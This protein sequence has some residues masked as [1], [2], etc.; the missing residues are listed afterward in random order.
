MKKLMIGFY[1]NRGNIKG[2]NGKKN[3]RQWNEINQYS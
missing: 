1:R 2:K 3:I